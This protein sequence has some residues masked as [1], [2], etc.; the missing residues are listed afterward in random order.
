MSHRSPASLT[1]FVA[2]AT[3]ITPAL[4]AD[5]IIVD[6][7]G[8]PA[9]FT[10]LQAAIDAAPDH[11]I[12]YLP[13]GAWEGSIVIDGKPLSIYTGPNS[14][15][16]R[17]ERLTI[18][19]LASG[20]NVVLRFFDIW[21]QSHSLEAAVEL[22]DNLGRIRF[23]YGG[24]QG[25][26]GVSYQFPQ[27]NSAAGPA[28]SIERC[29][30]VGF[31]DVIISGG[32]G[33]SIY[34]E[35]TQWFT[36][37]GAVG[38]DV[39]DSTLQFH[40]CEILGGRGGGL[41]DEDCAAASAGADALRAIHS[42]LY[43]YGSQIRGG[44]GGMPG[45]DIDLLWGTSCTGPGGAGGDGL[46][47]TNS[48]ARRLDSTIA[49]GVGTGG[50]PYGSAIVSAT[51]NVIE[52]PG[53]AREFDFPSPTHEGELELVRIAGEPGDIP[54]LLF[55]TAPT[56]TYFPAYSGVLLARLPWF[57]M[58]ALQPSTAPTG[59]QW[60][61][62]SSPFLG[63]GVEGFAFVVQLATIHGSQLQLGPAANVVF[64]GP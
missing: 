35:N 21:P 43:L 41:E 55:S 61:P 25:F 22:H 10:S 3:F 31:E 23:E 5:V 14:A 27:P 44:D 11:A 37:E 40:G 18:K 47:L 30:D 38:I 51:S 49:G 54:L 58:V 33:A 15:A 62:F 63:A 17:L 42:T 13:N 64:L 52:L 36:T 24:I 8:G 50:K 19:N 26:A 57:A 6:A 34:D 56:N 4:A 60:I 9:D 1:S 39:V 32:A 46:N 59:D 29:T 48:L 20:E 45:W 12:L 53:V 28:L 16:M 2:F 7:F